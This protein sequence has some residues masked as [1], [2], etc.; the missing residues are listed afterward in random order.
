MEAQVVRTGLLGGFC[1]KSIRQAF[2]S[3]SLGAAANSCLVC[4]LSLLMDTVGLRGREM[5]Q[6]RSCQEV[7]TFCLIEEKDVDQCKGTQDRVCKH[8]FVVS[9]H[10]TGRA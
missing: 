4:S 7:K 6:E 2:V 10:N 9:L 1:S 5:T 8:T 3:A